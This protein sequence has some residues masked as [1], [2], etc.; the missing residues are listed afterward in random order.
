MEWRDV[1]STPD[2]HLNPDRIQDFL[3]ERL[4]RADRDG[5][6]AHLQGCSRCRAEVDAWQRIFARLE[7]VDRLAPGADFADRVLEQL[8]AGAPVGSRLRRWVRDLVSRGS[9]DREHLGTPEILDRLDGALPAFR[10]RRVDTHLDGCGRCRDVMEQWRAVFRRLDGLGRMDP[11]EGFADT[12]MERV[13]T[14]AEQRPA[15][16]APEA[17]TF[18]PGWADRLRPSGR[19]GWTLAGG[20]VAA[21]AVAMVAAA[22]ALFAHPLLTPTNLVTFLWWRLTAVARTG[23]AAAV[24]TV[25]ESPLVFRVWE[26][27]QALAAVPLA[28]GA[29]VA[30][31]SVATVLALW[32]L[33]RN[34]FANPAARGRHAN[35]ST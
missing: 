11:P 9:S 6:R 33:R 22:L 31:F 28:A 8:P 2:G 23:L 12:V 19:R 26:A 17:S 13:R 27:A 16:A 18:L 20:A 32:I 35:R 24:A 34:L 1:T 25:A 4:P 7:E 29:G 30:A 21:P 5:V 10:R 14:A 15:A 3:D